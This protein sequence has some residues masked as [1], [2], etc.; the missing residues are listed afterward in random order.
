MSFETDTTE[1]VDYEHLATVVSAFVGQILASAMPQA[2]DE[3]RHEARQ[4]ITLRA[5][6]MAFSR[7]SSQREALVRLE[8]ALSDPRNVTPPEIL[9]AAMSGEAAVLAVYD[10]H[11]GG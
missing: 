9:R 5:A 1:T 4:V 2:S 10:N 11:T 8:S 3:I 7:G 6:A